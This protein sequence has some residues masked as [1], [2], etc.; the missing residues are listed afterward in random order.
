MLQL[1]VFIETGTYS[2]NTTGAMASLFREAHT[3][4][5]GHEQAVAAKHLLAEC[6][7]VTV[8]EGASEDILPRLLRQLADDRLLLW[9]DGHY[10]GPGTALGATECPLLAELAATAVCC[11]TFVVVVDDARYFE[12]APPA[13]HE[14]QEWP[15]TAQIMA[16]GNAPERQWFKFEDAYFW[17]PVNESTIPWMC[18]LQEARLIRLLR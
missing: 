17:V 6:A 4:E 13:P 16:V 9:L 10:S 3:I 7:N 14:A 1:T 12:A 2:G 8:H 5:L 15:T 11:N 18:N